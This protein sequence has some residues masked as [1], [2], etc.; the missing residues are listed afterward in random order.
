MISSFLSDEILEQRKRANNILAAEAM[1]IVRVR[2]NIFKLK[3]KTFVQCCTNSSIVVV[4]ANF[5]MEAD[6][7]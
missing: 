5:F 2:R 3:K 6:K 7:C 1:Y 4:F